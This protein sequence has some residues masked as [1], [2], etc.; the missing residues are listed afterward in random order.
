MPVTDYIDFTRPYVS[1]IGK[2]N[3]AKVLSGSHHCGDGV[4]TRYCNSLLEETMGGGRV[5]MT[6]SC[7]HA[8]EL[9]A[10]LVD[11]KIGDE[12][13][14]PSFAF[15]SCANAF[16]LRGAIPVFCDSRLD[17]INVDEMQLEANVTERT[18]AILVIHY[19]GVA[20]EMDAILAIARKHN[21]LVIEDLAHGPYAKYKGKNLGTFGDF[22]T[23]SFH[24]TKNFSCGEG[25]ALIVNN[26]KYFERAEILR[27]KGTNRSRFMRGQVDKYTWIDIGSSYLPSEFQMALLAGALDDRNKTQSGRLTIW[28]RYYQ[29]LGSWAASNGVALPIVPN[30]CEHSGHVFYLRMRDLDS[31]TKFM[32][33]MRA[34]KIETPFH[35]QALLNS[36]MGL[37]Y[38]IAQAF[39][40]ENANL[41]SDTLVRLPLWFGLSDQSQDAVITAI[42]QFVQ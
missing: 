22:A 21:L 38:S 18:K 1:E 9:S 26:M 6:S 10:L 20:C 36:P 7:T 17:K 42:E 14:I 13:L 34:N 41:L 37:R 11:L 16:A 5:L 24:H 30:G 3:L 39:G 40:C 4:Y 25:G 33:H 23:L 2:A 29:A 31:R 28:D 32:S 15:P 12:V 27:E 8:L 35:Y 19:G